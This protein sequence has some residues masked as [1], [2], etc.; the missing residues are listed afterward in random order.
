MAMVLAH[1][2][3]SWTVPADRGAAAYHTLSFIGG[4][5]SPLFLFLAGLAT[6]LSA[7]SKGR[8]EGSHAAGARLARRRGWEIFALGFVFRL[9]AQILGLGP[10]ENLFKVDMLNLMGLSMVL[11]SYVWQVATHHRWRVLMLAAVTGAIAMA[12]PIVRHTTWLA[13]LPDPL[14]AYLRPVGVYAAF[15]MFPWAGFL[16]AGVIVGDLVDAV[17]RAPQRQT[18]LQT[19]IA[20]CGGAGVVLAWLASLQPPLYDAVSFWHDS[21]TFFFIRL[22]L[23]ALLIPLTWVMAEA[24]PHM[25]I[26]PLALMGRSSLFVYW[27]HVEMVYGVIAEPIKHRLPLW[28]SVLGTGILAVFLYMLVIVKNRLVERHG[29]PGPW[30]LLAPVVK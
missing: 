29:L 26:E 5:A 6:A 1:V 16:F 7:A 30:R 15:P 17:R 2:V 11:A 4:I 3:D 20:I 8:S 14:E 13:G 22:G 19:G 9:Q 27:I 12:T 18:L 28:A 24:V 21:P 25:L 10:L 23:V